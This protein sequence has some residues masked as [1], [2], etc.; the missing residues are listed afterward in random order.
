[1]SSEQRAFSP[2]QVKVLQAWF[3]DNQRDLPW[4]K[5]RAPYEIL[6]SEIMLQQTTVAAVLAG[7][8]WERFLE[9]FPSIEAL[10]KASEYE[11]TAEWAGLGYYRRAR[12]LH[13][14]A[15]IIAETYG[16]NFPRELEQ[17]KQLPGLGDYT[18]S[19]VASFAYGLRTP[20]IDTNVAR[21]VSRFFA[22][23]HPSPTLPFR[24]AIHRTLEASL[25]KCGEQARVFSAGLMELGAL[26]CKSFQPQ[27]AQCP[28]QNGCEAR[29]RDLVDE[30]PLKPPPKSVVKVEMDGILLVRKD[31]TVLLRRVPHDDWHAGLWAIPASRRNPKTQSPLTPSLCESYRLWGELNPT[32]I[33]IFQTDFVVTRHKVTLHIWKVELFPFSTFGNEG[34]YANFPAGMVFSW[35]GT[36]HVWLAPKSTQG[37]GLGSP[38]SR[39]L[40]SLAAKAQGDLFPL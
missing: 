27:C 21:V 8:R 40:T 4:R 7:K 36:D 29:K 10:A 37:W 33:P 17:L 30:L 3:L 24:R 16:A 23:S 2:Q 22:I 14:T 19:A 26:I 13:Q 31:G 35:Q 38:Y 34:E 20:V 25:P 6:V 5:T 9:R 12:T 15:K 1:V 39:L 18:S 32:Q 11:V 28:L